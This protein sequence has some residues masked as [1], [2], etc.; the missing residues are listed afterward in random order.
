MLPAGEEKPLGQSSQAALPRAALYVPALHS[1]HEPPEKKER[2]LEKPALQTHAVDVVLP[3]GDV[4]EAGHPSHAT[5]VVQ[6][7][8]VGKLAQ[9]AT[10]APVVE[11]VCAR[12]PLYVPAAHSVHEPPLAP[13]VPALQ[14]QAVMSVLFGSEMES[15]GQSSQAA[16]PG[17]SLYVPAAHSVHALQLGPVYPALQV[18]AVKSVLAGS[19]MESLG[20]SSQAALPGVSL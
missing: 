10:T 5:S 12:Y 16:L 19:E 6:R 13:D 4:L 20:Q 3:A 18:Q 15:L 9:N 17:V 7:V 2:K 8:D 1:A 11:S 14:A